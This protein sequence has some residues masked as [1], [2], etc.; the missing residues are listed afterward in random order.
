MI[1]RRALAITNR[2]VAAFIADRAM[3][4]GAA[5]AFYTTFSLAPVLFLVVTITGFFIR[6]ERARQGVLEVVRQVIG[7]TGAEVA[8]GLLRGAFEA[9]PGALA[10][11]ASIVILLVA[12]TTVFAELQDS[13]NLIW[14][15]KP[16]DRWMVWDLVRIRLLSLSLI[17]VLGFLLLVSLVISMALAAVA[18][19]VQGP[20]G[21]AVVAQAVNMI[22]SYAIITAMFAATYRV[23]PDRKIPWRE[24]LVGAVA[25]ALLFSI[26]KVLIG[27]YIGSRDI[28]S[29]FGAASALVVVL[30]WVYFSS[31]IFLFGAELAKAYGE[32]RGTFQPPEE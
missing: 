18:K 11:T 5:I 31:Q 14:K 10:T 26:G 23:L 22:V 32:T 1:G 7:D 16:S 6:E 30:I 4:K 17:V 25:T 8:D 20:G 29:T 28:S 19:H 24:V 21:F 13:L 12:A 9:G 2:A 3:S 15:A 27:M